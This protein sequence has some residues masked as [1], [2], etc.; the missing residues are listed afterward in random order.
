MKNKLVTGCVVAIAVFGLMAY[1]VSGYQAEAKDNWTVFLSDKGV[2]SETILRYASLTRNDR[3]VLD[4][5]IGK[6]DLEIKEK[7][8][9]RY[10]YLDYWTSVL[11]TIAAVAIII[12]IVN[13]ARLLLG[14]IYVSPSFYRRFYMPA[15]DGINREKNEK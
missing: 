6:A 4:R 7:L 11:R 10:R 12:L 1:I 14:S 8:W 5:E 15:Q 3:A 9:E 2:D 13:A